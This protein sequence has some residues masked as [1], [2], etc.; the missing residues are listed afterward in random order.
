MIIDD[1]QDDPRQRG[2]LDKYFF[3]IA[4]YQIFTPCSWQ[5]MDIYLW[6]DEKWDVAL[7]ERVDWFKEVKIPYKMS[8]SYIE[9]LTEEHPRAYRLQLEFKTAQGVEAYKLRWSNGQL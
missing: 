7:R 9:C 3:P 6:E 5:D 2:W 8:V 4:V 1:I